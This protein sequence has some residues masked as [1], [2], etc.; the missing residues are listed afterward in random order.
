MYTLPAIQP[1]PNFFTFKDL[2]VVSTKND[3]YLDVFSK[4]KTSFIDLH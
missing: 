2:Y 4:S 3:V 1:P